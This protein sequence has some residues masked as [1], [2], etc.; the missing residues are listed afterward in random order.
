M[1]FKCQTYT[2]ACIFLRSMSSGVNFKLIFTSKHLTFFSWPFSN[3]FLNVVHWAV[4]N[5]LNHWMKSLFINHFII[6][7]I[8]ELPKTQKCQSKSLA[9][10]YRNPTSKTFKKRKYKNQVDLT[11]K[12]PKIFKNGQNFQMF[13]SILR[14]K[15]FKNNT[16]SQQTKKHKQSL[17]YFFTRQFFNHS[18]YQMKFRKKSRPFLKFKI[19]Q[20]RNHFIFRVDASPQHNPSAEIYNQSS[21]KCRLWRRRAESSAAA[22]QYRGRRSLKILFYCIGTTKAVLAETWLKN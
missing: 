18:F 7:K 20:E 22:D 2:K 4:L 8:Q 6:V 14:W 21:G 10:Q 12:S 17:Y 16:F 11:K 15:E 13:R 1:F 3:S 9:G 5:H 19:V